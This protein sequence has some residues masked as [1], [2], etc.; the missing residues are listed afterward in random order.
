M[1]SRKKINQKIILVQQNLS[2]YRWS[3]KTKF[4]YFQNCSFLVIKKKQQSILAYGLKFI[5]TLFSKEYGTMIP[6][7]ETAYHTVLCK[8]VGE[9]SAFYQIPSNKNIIY[10]SIIRCENVVHHW[11]EQWHMKQAMTNFRVYFSRQSNKL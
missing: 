5:L 2:K 10:L 6:E 8:R 7:F 4:A 1:P 9:V 11:K 3:C